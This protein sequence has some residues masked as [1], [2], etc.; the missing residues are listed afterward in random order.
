MSRDQSPWARS[1]SRRGTAENGCRRCGGDSV[2]RRLGIGRTT[3]LESC[4][5][6]APYR[7]AITMPTVVGRFGLAGVSPLA[8]ERFPP[9]LQE[10]DEGF[11]TVVPCRERRSFCPERAQ[12]CAARFSGNC[13]LRSGVPR[14]APTNASRRAS[15][16]RCSLPLCELRGRYADARSRARQIHEAGRRRQCKEDRDVRHY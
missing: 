12:C 13:L 11:S 4:R 6:T 1:P 14:L 7:Y 15:A 2:S 9:Y 16:T 3:S 8:L 5:L 10:E